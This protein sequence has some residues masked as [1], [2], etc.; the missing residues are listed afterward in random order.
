[1]SI[2]NNE[3]I[4][5]LEEDGIRKVGI[6]DQRRK[7]YLCSELTLPQVFSLQAICGYTWPGIEFGEPPSCPYTFFEVH[8]Y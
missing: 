7:H 3:E 6:T 8:I 5:V 1:M 4:N 2:P